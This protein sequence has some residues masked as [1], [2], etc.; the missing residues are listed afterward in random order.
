MAAKKNVQVD[1]HP[2]SHYGSIIET[3]EEYEKLMELTDESIVG[4][5]PDTG[6]IVRGGLDLLSTLKKYSSRIRNFHFKDVTSDG[7]WK[8]MGDGICDFKGIIKLLEDT[9]YKGWIIGE[10]E[11]DDARRDQ[12]SAV[13]KNMQYLK[14]IGQ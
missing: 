12:K 13:T 5:T 10:E 3:A 6:H 7:K 9:G 1:V 14:S 8:V 2:H 11:S 4:W